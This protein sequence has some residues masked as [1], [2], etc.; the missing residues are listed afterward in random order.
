MI[1]LIHIFRNLRHRRNLWFKFSAPSPPPMA[2]FLNLIN[3]VNP[4]KILT[5]KILSKISSP[6]RLTSDF[7]LLTCNFQLLLHLAY[8]NFSPNVSAQ[9]KRQK[10]PVIAA[11]K[12]GECLSKH[13]QNMPKVAHFLSKHDHFLTKIVRNI[14]KYSKIPPFSGYA[15]SIIPHFYPPKPVNFA[16]V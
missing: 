1:S 3:L 10:R 9:R 13:V 8:L 7:Q 12:T 14:Q 16:R 15:T 5:V 11:R 2:K 6:S 4:V